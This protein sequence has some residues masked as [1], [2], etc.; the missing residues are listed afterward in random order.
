MSTQDK[1]KGELKE[2]RRIPGRSPGTAVRGRY[3]LKASLTFTAE[4]YLKGPLISVA[5]ATG[6]T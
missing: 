3:F 1:A 6:L 2:R 5:Q 4:A